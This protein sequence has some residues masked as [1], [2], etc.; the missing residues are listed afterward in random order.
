MQQTIDETQRRRVKQMNYNIQNNITPQPIKKAIENNALNF[1]T[2]TKTSEKAYSSSYQNNNSAQHNISYKVAEH[3]ETYNK[4]S[5]T[6]NIE[7]R[8]NNLRN[9]MKKAAANFDFIEAAALRDEL[10]RLEQEYNL[11]D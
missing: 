11:N 4:S 9:S 10:L 1:Q 6:I 2:S 5:E 3:K 7:E 8:I